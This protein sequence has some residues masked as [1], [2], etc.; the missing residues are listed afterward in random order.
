MTVRKAYLFVDGTIMAFGKDWKVIPEYRGPDT[1][2]IP[3]LRRD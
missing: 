1:D 2:I 3:K